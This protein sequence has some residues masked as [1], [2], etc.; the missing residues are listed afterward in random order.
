[1]AT[2]NLGGTRCMHSEPAWEGQGHRAEALEVRVRLQL[3]LAPQRGLVR[4]RRAL[5]VPRARRH[6]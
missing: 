6:S 3:L 4:H 2:G 1:M 5:A